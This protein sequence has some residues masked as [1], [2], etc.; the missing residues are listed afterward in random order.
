MCTRWYINVITSEKNITWQV[1]NSFLCL[2]QMQE[3]IMKKKED[4]IG[5]I[6]PPPPKEKT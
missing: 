4:T 6:N 2:K 1:S 3:K 5:A